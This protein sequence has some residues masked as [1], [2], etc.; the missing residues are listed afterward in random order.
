MIN[1]SM[2]AAPRVG[3][4]TWRIIGAVALTVWLTAATSAQAAPTWLAPV[5]VSSPTTGNSQTPVDVAVAPDGTTVAVWR[6]FDGTNSRIQAAVRP[7]GGSFAAAVTLSDAGVNASQPSV[8]IDSVGTTT[9]VWEQDQG[10]LE[11]IKA[12]R[13]P[14]GGPFGGVQTLSDTGKT[15]FS[16][17]VA[18]N[19]N[20]HAVAAWVVYD[21]ATSRYQLEAATRSPGATDF[22]S[23]NTILGGLRVLLQHPGGRD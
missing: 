23:R 11:V 20:G 1:S 21:G 4:R 13:R 9:A 2:F 17:Q 19:G 14:S 18:A 10:G 7:A 6:R 12:R 15:S 22:S 8:A 16:P 3:A 5:R